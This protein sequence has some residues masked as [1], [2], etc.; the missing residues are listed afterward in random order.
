MQPKA[1]LKEEESRKREGGCRA[2]VLTG[3]PLRARLSQRWGDL[4]VFM[5]R[6]EGLKEKE[7][8]KTG[9]GD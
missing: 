2:E 4:S 8:K 7:R 9:K 3:S 1:R 6:G 5:G